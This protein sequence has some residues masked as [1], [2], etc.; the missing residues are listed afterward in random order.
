MRPIAVAVGCGAV[1]AAMVPVGLSA[2]ASM[3][4]SPSSAIFFLKDLMPFAKSPTRTRTIC[5]PYSV[6]YRNRHGRGD[7]GAGYGTFLHH[8][9]AR[10]ALVSESRKGWSVSREA[11]RAFTA[12]PGEALRSRYGYPALTCR[13][14]NP[15]TIMRTWT[16]RKM[17]PF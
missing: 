1:G 3:E 4:A 8:Q 16:V 7:S 11:R 15:K 9:G 2:L 14:K 10:E 12:N 13:P 5:C 17:E 6:E